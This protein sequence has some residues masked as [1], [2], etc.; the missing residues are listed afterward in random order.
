M[1]AV[2]DADDQALY[3]FFTEAETS[4]AYFHLIQGVLRRA[5]IPVLRTLPSRGRDG[6]GGR[7][8]HRIGQTWERA[9]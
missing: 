4:A 5:G 3:A 6:L 9:P 2:D 8:R 1:A 7:S